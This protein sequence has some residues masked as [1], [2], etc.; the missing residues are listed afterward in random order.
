MAE[1]PYASVEMCGIGSNDAA[2]TAM[3]IGLK[4]EQTDTPRS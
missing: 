1:S 4:A 3:G 2:V